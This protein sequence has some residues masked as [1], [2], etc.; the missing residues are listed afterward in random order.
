MTAV[1]ILNR[2]VT[3]TIALDG[4]ATA[5]VAA[6]PAIRVEIATVGVQGPLGS[7]GAIG[8][9]PWTDVTDKP[10][11][12]PPSAHVHAYA[13]LTGLPTLFSGAYAD[14][15]GL[16]ATFPPSAHV[17]A[18][19]SLTGLPT[20]FSGAYADLSGVPT[21]GTAAAAA[22]ADFATAAQGALADSAVQPAALAAKQDALVAGTNIKTVNGVSLLGSGDLA[23]AGGSPL[24][25]WFI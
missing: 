6:Q 14:L 9:V 15:S 20:L 3:A 21:L 22:V 5:V 23:V 10:A 4:G 12:F 18:Y 24:M 11:T 25:G 17:H 1:F 8:S 7:V 2:P 16:P 13:S 19:A